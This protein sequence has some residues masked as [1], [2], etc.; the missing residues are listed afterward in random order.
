MATMTMTK[1][2]GFMKDIEEMELM[3]RG[4]QLLTVEQW[5]KFA[6]CPTCNKQKCS[7]CVSGPSGLTEV[8]QFERFHITIDDLED[9]YMPRKLWN[10][11]IQ[12]CSC[13][14]RQHIL[15][16]VSEAIQ[17]E[18]YYIPDLEEAMLRAAKEEKE[19]SLH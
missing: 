1:K 6:F 5:E 3:F 13:G 7:A 10:I 14:S 18:I 19:R 11:E 17:P 12:C 4:K 9:E 2:G 16:W 15:D 8:E